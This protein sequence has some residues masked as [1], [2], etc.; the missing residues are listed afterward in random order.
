M[1]KKLRY[2]KYTV[3]NWN[4]A[5][6][7]VIKSAKSLRGRIQVLLIAAYVH[8]AEHGD[9]TLVNRL[10]TAID[11][12]DGFNAKPMLKH[13]ETYCGLTRT[14]AWD[15]EKKK[16]VMPKVFNGHTSQ[17]F[18]LD[19][20]DAGKAKMWWET[21]K[22]ASAFADVSYDAILN[23]AFDEINNQEQRALKA[24]NDA[25]V[26]LEDFRAEHVDPTLSGAT[27]R[28][29]LSFMKVDDAI[30]EASCQEAALLAT[31]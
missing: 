4:K 10:C 15:E 28:R 19:S 24:A 26:E 2:T 18:A 13:V 5:F 30:I 17:E 16:E 7:S 6:D 9:Y 14:P 12:L 23:K 21:I 8:Y 22:V 20:M 25:G 31:G 11:E 3:T 27:T 29:V 1:S